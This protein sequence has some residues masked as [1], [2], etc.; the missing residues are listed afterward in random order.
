MRVLVHLFGIT[1]LKDPPEQ[2]R[3]NL[4]V[5]SGEGGELSGGEATMHRDGRGQGPPP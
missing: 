1:R 4:E 5:L 3:I 2:N